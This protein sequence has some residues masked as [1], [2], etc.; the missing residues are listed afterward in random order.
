M[1]YKQEKVPMLHSCVI[2]PLTHG[3]IWIKFS[4]AFLYHV[5]YFATYFIS[6]MLSFL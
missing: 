6:E 4:G 2:G 3:K 5:H 1:W